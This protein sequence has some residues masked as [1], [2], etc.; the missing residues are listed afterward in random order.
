MYKYTKKMHELAVK[1]ISRIHAP[2]VCLVK[3]DVVH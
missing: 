1:R 3:A 2:P